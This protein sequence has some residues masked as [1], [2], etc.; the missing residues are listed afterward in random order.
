MEGGEADSWG[1]SGI[2]EEV[3]LGDE[4]GAWEVGVVYFDCDFTTCILPIGVGEVV[5]EGAI[6]GDD[7]ASSIEPGPSGVAVVA[8]T[9]DELSLHIESRIAFFAVGDDF[10]FTGSEGCTH[11]ISD[12]VVGFV[13]VFRSGVE[14]T[15]V[16]P[17]VRVIEE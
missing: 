11:E 7:V 14:P 13:D 2:L 5:D 10:S 15:G 3:G 4:G 6:G 9:F 17:S 8:F 1:I 16:A 12:E